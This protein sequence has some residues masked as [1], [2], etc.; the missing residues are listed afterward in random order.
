MKRAWIK[1]AVAGVVLAL[2]AGGVLKALNSR[3]AQKEALEQSTRA[4]SNELELAPSD[5]LKAEPKTL[6]QGLPVSGALKAINTAVV[7]ARVAGELQGL[8]LR[9]G[10]AVSAGQVIARID[11][12][13]YLAR[14]KQAKEQADAARTQIEI[15]QRQFDNNRGLVDQGFISKTALEASSSTLIGAQATYKAALAAVDV[16]KKQLDDS[17]MLAPLSGQISQRLAQP[18]ERMAIDGRVVEI[19]DLK[20][21]ELEAT[22]SATESMQVRVGQGA[23]LQIEGTT[24]TVNAKVARISPSTLPGS[25]SVLVYL[26]VEGTPGLRQGLFAQGML[27]TQLKQGLA[28]PL[29]AVR[30]DKPQPYVQVVEDNKIAH[31]NVS[32]GARGSTADSAQIWVLVDG[33]KDQE[34][35]VRG[36]LG[37]LREGTAVTLSKAR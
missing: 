33:L 35:V 8:T 22:L 3:K 9:E 2:L 4:V 19:V 12:T 15:A 24:Q 37:S 13:E 17:V 14:L 10:D 26:S 29:D 18:G 20:Q 27:G 16:A 11:P 32:L 6:A 23:Q 31:R 21:L 7:K 36:E 1:W 25:R 5:V 34:V 30:T 28:V